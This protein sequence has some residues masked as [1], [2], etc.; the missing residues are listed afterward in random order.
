[1][2]VGDNIHRFRFETETGT[3]NQ[4]FPVLR[5]FI[6][7]FLIYFAKQLNNFLFLNV[8]R[9]NFY[10]NIGLKDKL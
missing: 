6:W 1:M 8:F 7:D 2:K 4:V 10:K 9:A 3:K 5:Y